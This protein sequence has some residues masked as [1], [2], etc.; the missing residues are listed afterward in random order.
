MTN[1]D[2]AP[3]LAVEF[4]YTDG[5]VGVYADHLLD[6]PE[7]GLWAQFEHFDEDRKGAHSHIVIRPDD[8]A[9]QATSNRLLASVQALRTCEL[10]V[11][12]YARGE[13]NGGSVDWGDVDLA[14]EVAC[15]AVAIAQDRPI[16]DTGESY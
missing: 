13:A 1:D 2:I 15:Q 9:G 11:E 6:G 7:Y 5:D 8:D 4:H 16:S 10:L 3:H 14:W 12:A